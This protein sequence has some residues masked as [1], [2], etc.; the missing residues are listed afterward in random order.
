MTGRLVAELFVFWAAGFLGS[1]FGG[2]LGSLFGLVIARGRLT[3]V[4]PL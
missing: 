1:L 3:Q 2:F 4:T